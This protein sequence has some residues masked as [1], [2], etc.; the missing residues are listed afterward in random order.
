MAVTSPV[1][2]QSPTCPF[3]MSE[4]VITTSKSSDDMYWRC[5]TC[6]Q[7]WNPSRLKLFTPRA[8]P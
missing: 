6:G 1:A 3:C 7:I 5:R 8:R 4:Q 2:P